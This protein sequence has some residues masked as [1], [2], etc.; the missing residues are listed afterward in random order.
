MRKKA[1]SRKSNN[2]KVLADNRK[3]KKLK[4]LLLFLIISVSYLAYLDVK[5][6]RKFEGRIW[7]LPARVYARPLE[8]YEGKA[9]SPDQLLIELKM[10]NYALVQGDLIG[11]GQ[12]RRFG[13]SFD[14]VTRAFEYW[15]GNEESRRIS[16]NI[17]NGKISR[18]ENAINNESLALVRF[19]PAY[20]AGIFPA[21][22]EDRE[23]VRL[24]EVPSELIT[25]L[26]MLEDRRFY[27]HPGVDIRSIARAFVA[28]IKAGRTVQGG[29]TMT[30]QLVK[31]LFLTSRQNLWRKINEALMAVMLDSQYS[32]K[33]ILE[34][35][36]NE[37]YLGQD[38]DRAIHGF[39]LAS[40]Y[41]FG[42][43]LHQLAIDEMALL[44]G[45]VKGASY[46]NPVKHPQ[47]AKE[48][49]DIVLSLIYKNGL[50][51]HDQYIVLTRKQ[52]KIAR[53]S[54][55]ERYPAYLDL[56]K[57]QLKTTYNSNDLKSEGLRIFTTFNPYVQHQTEN[58]VVSVV[59]ELSSDKKL[60][61][62]AIVVS[63]NNGEVLAVVA[64]RKP[65]FPGFNRALDVQRHIGSLIKPIIY[66]SALKRS[67][68]YTLA[69]LLNDSRLRVEGEDKKIWQPENYDHKYHGDV[70]LYDALLNSYNIPAA[71][72]GL[73]VGLGEISKTVQQ[74]GNRSRLPPYP[75]MTLGAV[76]MSPFDVA[77]IYQTFAANGFHS[78]LRSVV[79]V[80]DIKGKA[81][82]RYPVDVAR[83]V[84]PATIALVNH[85]MLGVTEQ[86]TARRLSKELNIKVAGKTGT[87]D[88]LKD[89]WF[90]GFSGDA[91][92]VVWTG[93]DRDRSSGLT[94]SS[95][96]LRIWSRIIGSI[97]STSFEVLMPDNIVLKWV[98]R[99]SGLLSGQGCENAIE[100]PFIKGSEPKAE[101]ECAD[102]SS[103]SWF[104]SIFGD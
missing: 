47:R 27:D 97:S 76:D 63:P 72:V 79:A 45:M 59:P 85:A 11:P 36:I 58:A 43:T 42:K 40:L 53:H 4:I 61:A 12:Y 24:D 23:L 67:D 10:L 102:G 44:V 52:I 81:L 2:K 95:G 26:I 69:S 3:S 86:G 49:R 60:Q 64:D 90:A 37:I 33:K 103:G 84:D 28:N 101:A 96:A 9:L 73:D 55:R 51:S 29:S 18:L 71:R 50:I 77:S 65:D 92:A 91:V 57:R 56:V 87:S 48:R 16:L 68:K 39:G 20:L 66:L 5:I 94:G 62:A 7:Q 41:Y 99:K 89:S 75:S 78:P 82:K 104:D 35:Y 14:I 100:L 83:E 19:D 80:L 38:Q 25:M 8:L 32:K 30:Q 17:S 93:Y 46:Y 6:I 13:N 88:D 15:D 74:L 1:K 70:I 54:K 21:H 34:T 22:G 98:D 31:N